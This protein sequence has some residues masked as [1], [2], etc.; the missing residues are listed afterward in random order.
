MTRLSLKAFGGVLALCL[1]LS[2][3]FSTAA[4]AAPPTGGTLGFVVR[5]GFTAVFKGKFV[6]E[7]PAGLTQSYDEIW[8][9]N[10]SREERA[11]VTQNGLFPPLNR[12]P[13]AM[14]RGPK[15]ENVCFHPTSVQDPPMR[16]VEG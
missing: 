5:D 8:W 6:D 2:P 13:W 7:C 12:L 14:R 16:V 11:K 9:R 3:V 15:G 1:A 4:L 10:P